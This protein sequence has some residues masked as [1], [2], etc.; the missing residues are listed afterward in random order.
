[1]NILSLPS[2]PPLIQIR[3]LERGLPANTLASLAEMFGI[4]KKRIIGAL[5]FAE[6][7]LVNREGP[8]ARFTLVESER[9]LRLLRLRYILRDAFSSDKAVGEWIETPASSLD[10]KTPLAMLATDVG[11]AKVT[12]L[13]LATV[14]GVPI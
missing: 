14:H 4:P 12:N 13:A 3:A 5:R 7:P 11:T 6:R 9:L 8:R 1:M 2:Q 10:G